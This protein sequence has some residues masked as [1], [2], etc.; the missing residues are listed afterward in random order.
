MDVGCFLAHDFRRLSYDG[1]PT[2]NLYGVDIASHWD[3]G[4]EMFRDRD[5]FSAHF[6]EADILT[7]SDPQSPLSSLK[8]QVDIISIAQV[9]HQV[10]T[11]TITPAP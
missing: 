10:S 1:A 5:S 4:F 11:V 2:E 9:L 7:A 3:V 6:I 8:G